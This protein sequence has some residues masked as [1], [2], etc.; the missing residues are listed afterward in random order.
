MLCVLGAAVWLCAA[1]DVFWRLD[2]GL[3]DA[4]LPTGPAPDDVM[5]V[6]ID[7]ASIAELGHWPWRRA[8]HAALLDKLNALGA[9]AVALDLLLSEADTGAPQED[10]ALAAAMTRGA[11]VV[12]PLFVEMVPGHAP[13]LRPP[14]PVFAT[15]AAGVGHANLELDRDGSVRSVF[16]QEGIGSPQWPHFAVALLE[17]APGAAP[18]VLR[19]ARH[20][21]LAGAGPETWVR[22]HRIGIPYLGPPGHVSRVSYVDVL[23][24]AVPAEAIRGKIVLVG[25]T[26]HGI[27]DAYPTPRS[28]QS[29]AM[30]GIEITANVLQ[31][32]RAGTDIEPVPRPVAAA[33]SLL[34]LVLGAVLLL[35]LAPWQS[36]V[37]MVVLGVGTLGASVLALQAGHAWWPPSS[38]LAGLLVMYPVWSWRRLAVTQRFLEQ[39]FA[40]L[41]KERFP[42]LGGP[43]ES[44]GALSSADFLERRIEL[45]RRATQR[46]RGVRRL[47][48]DTLSGLPDATVLLDEAGRIVLANQAAAQ[49]FGVGDAG[50]LE[51]LDIDAL[52]LARVQSAESSF[53]SL[54]TGAPITV[55]A[56]LSPTNVRVLIRAV[57]FRGI[58]GERVG[59][60]LAL[61]DITALR[62]AQAEREDVLRFLSHD[63]KSPASSL[64]GLAQLQRDPDRALAPAELSG[65]LE[66]LAQRLLTL[67]DGFVALVRAEAADP[68]AFEDFDLGDAIKDAD[69]E[70]W[71]SAHARGSAITTRVPEEA[72]LVHGDRQLLARAFVNLLSNGLKFSD[73]GSDIEMTLEC[74]AG[75]A[76]VEIADHGRGIAPLVVPS[77]FR[78]FSRG[79]SQ[80]ATDPGGA[81]L[82]LAFVRVVAE[83]HRGRVWVAAREGYGAVLRFAL[84]IA[85]APD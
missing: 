37:G 21:D 63:M 57:P 24:G 44:V 62:A 52:L 78:R 54:S 73:A 50:E 4:A 61:A 47:F 85:A 68:G 51:N 34:P 65:R 3:Y 84:P 32:V 56:T 59:T 58:P 83:K 26:A 27:G 64:L 79:P 48:S 14:I 5:I 7:D 74:V 49:L 60:I 15:A 11:P 10:A 71:A 53:D 66:L 25:A 31:T 17:A 22:D 82:G 75:E 35:V 28:G 16:L 30:S 23:R 70:V 76:V 41:A 9:R 55:E 6:A 20:P 77:L 1:G 46:L 18:V 45:L 40:A 39:E 69:D 2:F 72:T 42:L 67:V 8:L 33:L 80:G 12:L 13:R 29:V 43:L 36:L 38:A 81:G 19:G